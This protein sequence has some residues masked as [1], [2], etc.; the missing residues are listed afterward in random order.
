[1]YKDKKI[2]GV[3]TARGGSKG[4]PGKNIRPLGGKPL[5]AWTIEAAKQSKYIDSVIL[6]SDDP[7]ICQTARDFGCEVPF[8]RPEHLATD[9]ADSISVLLHALEQVSENYHGLVVLQ[10]T[11]PFRSAFHIDQS[12]ELYDGDSQNSVVSVTE[13]QKSPHWMYWIDKESRHMTP[14]LKS[15]NSYSRRQDI[16][17][18]YVL[19]GALYVIGVER[20]KRDKKLL[21][22]N[23]LAYVMNEKDSVDIDTIIDFK[24]AQFILEN[25]SND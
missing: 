3:I 13:S 5:I 24:T 7:E 1:M 17:N 25:E 15:D 9:T 11:S 12:I 20:F 10:P 23:T 19:N 22:E 4:L 18:A 16:P 2:L 21:D 14:V 6:S 8:I